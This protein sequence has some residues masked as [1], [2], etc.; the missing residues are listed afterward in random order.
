MKAA[1][2]VRSQVEIADAILT[3]TDAQWA[4]L[5][6]TA[7]KYAWLYRDG[8]EDLLNEA[9]GRALAGTRKCPDNVDVVKFLCDAM[10]GIADDEA[11][12]AR[13]NVQT[14]PLLAPGADVPGSVD[15]GDRTMNAEQMMMG[16][17]TNE[18]LRQDLLALFPHDQQAR[19]LIDGLAAEFEGEELREVAGLDPTTYATK[20]RLI[21]RTV[22]KHYPNGW[23]P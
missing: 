20:R 16:L 1:V 14:V 17:H 3:F 13:N 7:R 23:K 4:R 15:P 5:R 8:E 9:F 18:A 21:R 11:K 12:K 10:M 22:D 19:D 2:A 6:M